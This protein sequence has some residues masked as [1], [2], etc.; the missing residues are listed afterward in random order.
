MQSDATTCSKPVTKSEERR[1]FFGNSGRMLWPAST[2]LS[3]TACIA[4]QQQ[5]TGATSSKELR[6]MLPSRVS[7][8]RWQSRVAKFVLAPAPFPAPTVQTAF[9][10]VSSPNGSLPACGLQHVESTKSLSEPACMSVCARVHACVVS[11]CECVYVCIYIYIY[12]YIYICV[13]ARVRARVR[14]WVCVC[15][16]LFLSECV[17]AWPA[18]QLCW[19]VVVRALFFFTCT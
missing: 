6:S 8:G 3:S 19:W 11:V 15:A 7:A 14:A 18:G 16:R 2:M 17:C 9:N 1:F 12:I 5:N 4:W 10:L 13:R